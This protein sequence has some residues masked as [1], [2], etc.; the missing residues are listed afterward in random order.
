MEILIYALLF[1][2]GLLAGHSFYYNRITYLRRENILL[3]EALTSHTEETRKTFVWLKEQ[4]HHKDMITAAIGNMREIA[5]RFETG[6]LP[7]DEAH[8]QYEMLR[9]EAQLHF[10]EL[11]EDLR[12]WYTQQAVERGGT[13]L[14]HNDTK[15]ES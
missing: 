9:A 14:F 10:D 5:V 4:I 8:I 1:V 12:N 2:I 7:A 6:A 11:D 3:R 13:M 15:D